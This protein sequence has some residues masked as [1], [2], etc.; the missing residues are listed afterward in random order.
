VQFGS[1]V[2]IGWDGL[3]VAQPAEPVST[4][5][6]YTNSTCEITTDGKVLPVCWRQKNTWATANA[7]SGAPAVSDFDQD[8][9]LIPI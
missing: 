3:G 9:S 4:G 7:F 8:R 6:S 2:G 5:T 1:V